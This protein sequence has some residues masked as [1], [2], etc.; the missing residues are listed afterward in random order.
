MGVGIDGS[1]WHGSGGQSAE[2]GV[3]EVERVGLGSGGLMRLDTRY[4]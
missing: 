1:C 3:C 4:V 2:E